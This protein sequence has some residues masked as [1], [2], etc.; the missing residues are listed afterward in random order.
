[1]AGGIRQHRL[2]LLRTRRIAGNLHVR[3]LARLANVSDLM[4][5]KI[6]NGD[7]CAPEI[8]ERLLD[9]LGP[10]VAITSSSAANPT[11]LLTAAHKFVTG[12]TVTITGHT[13]ATN[14]ITGD[15]VVTVV[16][17]THFTVAIDE[18]GGGGTNGTARLS[19]VSLGLA[20]L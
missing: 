4:I 5:H 20:R 7:P 18:T 16:D 17:T 10:L 1:M 2:D 6:E 11:S 13:G 3:E 8:T 12:D 9:A 14:P 19:P 15:N